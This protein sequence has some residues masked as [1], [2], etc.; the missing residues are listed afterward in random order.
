MKNIKVKASLA[1][2]SIV[3]AIS[4]QAAFQEGEGAD[5]IQ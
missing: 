1:V 5:I 4:A 2:L 3:T